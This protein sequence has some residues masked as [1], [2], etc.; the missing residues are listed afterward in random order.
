[1]FSTNFKDFDPLTGEPPEFFAS[2][3]SGIMERARIILKGRSLDEI[4]AIGSLVAWLS[5]GAS[6][7]ENGLARLAEKLD[8]EEA[9]EDTDGEYPS[10][11]CTQEI[12]FYINKIDL[13]DNEYISDLTWAEVFAV[14]ALLEVSEAIDDQTFL[15]STGVPENNRRYYDNLGYGA[16]QAMEAVCKAESLIDNQSTKESVKK[17]SLRAKRNVFEKHRKYNALYNDLFQF[18]K[19]NSFSKYVDC[20]EAF[21]QNTHEDD[22]YFLKKTNRTA[23]LT[24]ALSE[25]VRGKR[26]IRE[27]PEEYD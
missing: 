12:S 13:D 15:M 20:V 1:M 17:V 8:R 27:S 16:I 25:I 3:Y 23:L 7:W 5:D 2:E 9:G 11:T 26:I 10:G 21:I 14:I 4:I 18:Y 22:M 6:F 24:R 19:D